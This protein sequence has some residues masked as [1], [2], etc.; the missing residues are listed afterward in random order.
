MIGAQKYL[1][2]REKAFFL[3]DLMDMQIPN[4]DRIQDEVNWFTK[5]F[6]YRNSDAPWGNSKDAISRSI[7]KIIGNCNLK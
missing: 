1:S 3:L 4:M 7:E 6:D 2:P 5:K